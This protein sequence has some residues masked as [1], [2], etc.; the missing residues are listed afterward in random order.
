LE[1]LELALLAAR[2]AED[3]K[4][5]DVMVMEMR[6]LTTVT[7][8]FVLASGR[9][10]IQVRAI[11]DHVEDEASRRGARLLHRE[12]YERG[13]WVLLDYGDVVVHVLCEEE[14][15]FYALERLWG[16]APVVYSAGSP[17]LAVESGN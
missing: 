14:R 9:T 10:P 5:R 2:A 15:K 1:A 7:D 3:R 17:A 12:G 11:A 8:Y 13:R 6:E 4:A 16:D